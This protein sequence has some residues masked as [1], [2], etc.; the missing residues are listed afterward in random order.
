MDGQIKPGGNI[1]N[2]FDNKPFPKY[3]YSRAARGPLKQIHKYSENTIVLKYSDIRI[4][5]S[6]EIC[7]T[8][9]SICSYVW[10]I[11]A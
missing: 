8:L 2:L 3:V 4:F 11:Y 7:T 6:K 10:Y 5:V 9:I 1:A